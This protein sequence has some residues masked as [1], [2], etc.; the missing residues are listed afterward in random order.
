MMRVTSCVDKDLGGTVPGLLSSSVVELADDRAAARM[1]KRNRMLGIND[2]VKQCTS[3]TRQE[4]LCR[5]KKQHDLD[6]EGELP[7]RRCLHLTS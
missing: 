2:G 4:I 5:D 6:K 3:G 1:L 7:S